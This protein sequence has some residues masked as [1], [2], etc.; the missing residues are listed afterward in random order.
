MHTRNLILLAGIAN[1]VVAAAHAEVFEPAPAKLGFADVAPL[2]TVRE[3]YDSNVFRQT[4]GEEEAW[5]Q[6]MI[7]RMNAQALDGPHVY[8]LN[9]RGEAGFIDDRSSDNYVD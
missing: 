6:T 2:L 5:V 9:Y 4:K 1:S 7:L 8:A 3:E